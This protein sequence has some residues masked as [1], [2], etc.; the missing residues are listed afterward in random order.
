M[1]GVAPSYTLLRARYRS[2]L[3]PWP[4]SND[5]MQPLPRPNRDSAPPGN[6]ARDQQQSEHVGSTRL[7][8]PTGTMHDPARASTVTNPNPDGKKKRRHRGG[9]RKK[10][11]RQS[12]AAPS[13][14]S[15]IMSGPEGL[16]DPLIQQSEEM[17]GFH[18]GPSFYDSPSARRRPTIGNISDHSVDSEALLDHRYVRRA[19]QSSVC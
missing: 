8:A 2:V 15:A 12:F 14:T 17:D 9:K 1:C 4:S 6:Q 19:K 10:N 5:T 13:E 16:H 7:Q 18:R 3:L 11:R